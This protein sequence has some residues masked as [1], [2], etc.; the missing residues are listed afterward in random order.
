MEGRYPF[1]QLPGSSRQPPPPPPPPPPPSRAGASSTTDVHDYNYGFRYPPSIGRLAPGQAPPRQ[2]EAP[3][4]APLIEV[5]RC[6]PADEQKN[7]D[8]YCE[9]CD[10]EL[11]SAQAL[12]S[13]CRSHLKCTECAFE[14]APKIVKAHYQ[15]VHGK[16]SGSG[17]KAVTVAIPGC[18]VQ[19]F[20]ICVGNRPEDIQRWIEERKK[21]F[22]RQQQQDSMVDTTKSTKEVSNVS[23]PTGMS[24][25]LAGYGSSGSDSEDDNDTTVKRAER[26]VE[27]KVP[28]STPVACAT[29][30]ETIHGENEATSSTP[31]TQSKTSAQTVKHINR[32][33][34]F[35]SRNGSCLNGDACRFSHDTARDKIAAQPVNRNRKRKHTTSDTLLRKLL[36][37]DMERESVLMLQLLE[38]IVEKNFFGCNG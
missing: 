23:P 32:P 35:F 18:R 28:L 20:R 3:Q 4:P 16:F 21:R 30:D 15:G 8:F 17:F 19:R 31:T 1:F 22:P 7:K 9:P 13:H 2:S 29:S 25:L 27:D 33:C 34:Q 36:E 5:V 6:P 26:L 24:S 38:Y 11:E 12:K 10:L 37:S 14:G